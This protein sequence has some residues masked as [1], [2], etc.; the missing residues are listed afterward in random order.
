MVAL[1][2]LTLVLASLREHVSLPSVLLLYLLVVVTVA[3]IGGFL[4]RC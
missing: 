3:A 1:P 2:L 4:P